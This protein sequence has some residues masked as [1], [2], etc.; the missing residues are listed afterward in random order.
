MQGDDVVRADAGTFYAAPPGA[1]HGLVN[2]G[3]QVVLLN[4]H[5][6]ESRARRARFAAASRSVT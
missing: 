2:D 3:G 5:G 6:P 4:V 1:T